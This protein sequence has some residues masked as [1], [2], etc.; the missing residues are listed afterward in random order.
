MQPLFKIYVTLQN[1][2][3]EFKPSIPELTQTVNAVAK[4]AISTV[5]EM[6]RLSE[7]LAEG[8]AALKEGRES[9]YEKISKDDDVLK[10]LV[11]VMTGMREILPRMVKY[12][13]TWDRYK[14]IWDV[15]KDAFMRRYAKANRALTAF[16]TD[17]ARY[18]ELAS[19]IQSEEGYSNIGFIRVDSGPLKQARA[20]ARLPTHSPPAPHP[21][22][23]PLLTP[24][25]PRKQALMEHCK[26]WEAK[27]THLLNTNAADEIATLYEN[28]AKV[29]AAFKSK[30]LNLDQLADQ[31]N[32]LEA[33]QGG[34][35]KVEG[36]FQPLEDMYRML[37]KFE[38][39]VKDGELERLGNL[40][41]EWAGYRKL[42]TEVGTRLQKAKADFKDDLLN[43]LADMRTREQELR[44][45]FLRSA[46]FDGEMHGEAPALIDEYRNQ[47]AAVRKREKEMAAGL[48]IFAIEA[49]PN[50]ETATTEKELELLQVVWGMWDEW[51]GKMQGWKYGKFKEIDVTAIENDAAQVGKRLYKLSKEVKQWKVLDTLREKVDGM[52]KLMPLIMDLRN[53]AMRDRHWKGLM[54]EVGPPPFDP[55]TPPRPRRYLSPHPLPIPLIRWASRSTRTATTSRWRSCCSWD[56]RTT[57]KQS[58]AS[59][60]RRVRS[61]RSRTRW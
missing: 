53:P 13:T 54:E 3:V 34:L 23:T 20:A 16:E 33:E 26:K 32:L 6:P 15:D 31:I 25:S 5:G 40:R 1:S 61:W 9:F 48:K 29:T 19:D 4:A 59:R 2:K 52:K 55:H 47:C 22:S 46:P 60:R 10:V 56:W 17:I 50:K 18:R 51:E 21:T 45:D 41:S 14:H 8:D 11:H 58:R 35:E 38:V 27:F 57:P 36:R 37:E 30:P 12:I 39:Q 42:L 43:S 7:A 49:P 24:H 44:A 28:I